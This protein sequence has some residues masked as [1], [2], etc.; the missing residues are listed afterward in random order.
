MFHT[1]ISDR[2]KVLNKS[3]MYNRFILNG[4]QIKGKKVEPVTNKVVSVNTP[5]E[6]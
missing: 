5:G 2:A 1:W 4:K 6:Y 3:H